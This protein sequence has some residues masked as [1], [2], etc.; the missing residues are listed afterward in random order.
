MLTEATAN[1]DD[2][3]G[4]LRR[5]RLA[6]LSP[7]DAWP[8]EMPEVG[9]GGRAFAVG[10]S[11]VVELQGLMKH[12]TRGEEGFMATPMSRQAADRLRADLELSIRIARALDAISLGI[13]S[14]YRIGI[15]GDRQTKESVTLDA[16][17]EA[18]QM[19]PY[20]T[21]SRFAIYRSPPVHRRRRSWLFVLDGG[22]F[23]W[24]GHALG[25][26]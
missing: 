24:G 10:G 20:P 9:S 5:E 25:L 3:I 22:E 26:H 7:F 18:H 13:G 1:D 19:K 16:A 6:R 14:L 12:Y 17:I 21:A 8:L 4:R 2:P 15:T 23:S 11:V